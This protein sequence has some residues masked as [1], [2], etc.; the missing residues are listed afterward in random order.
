M[1]ERIWIIIA[2]L[3]LIVAAIFLLQDNINVAFVAATL[4]VVAWFL[5]LRERLR[6]SIVMTGDAQESDHNTSGEHDE[7]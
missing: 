7:N 1:R 6:K 3:C 2:G 4:G 5:N